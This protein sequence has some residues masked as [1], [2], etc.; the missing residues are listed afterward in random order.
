MWRSWFALYYHHF[1]WVPH[2]MHFDHDIYF[3]IFML[4]SFAASAGVDEMMC[5]WECFPENRDHLRRQSSSTLALDQ[6]IRWKSVFSTGSD[7][8]MTVVCSVTN[9]S[10]RCDCYN[11]I[12]QCFVFV[13]ES[14][15]KV[16]ITVGDSLFSS[17]KLKAQVSFFFFCLAPFVCPSVCP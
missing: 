14:E 12:Y 13:L 4:L 2:E 8:S 5:I 15:L 10:K 3:V 7:D 6:M 1:F 11:C 9:G 16:C 17:H